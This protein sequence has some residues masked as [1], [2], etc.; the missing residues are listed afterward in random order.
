M[1]R[2]YH[3]ETL[4]QTIVTNRVTIAMNYTLVRWVRDKD[5]NYYRGLLDNV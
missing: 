5:C 4:D 3:L 1:M 2:I